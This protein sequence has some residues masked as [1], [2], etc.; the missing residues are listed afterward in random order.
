MPKED[1]VKDGGGRKRD[2]EEPP[3]FS[4]MK[5][6]KLVERARELADRYRVK[7]GER[8]RLSDVDPDDT[9]WL[10]EEDKPSPRRRS[11]GASRRSPS[12]RTCSTPRTAGACC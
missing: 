1:A 2:A 5:L 10:K 3:A 11:S 9:A 4:A 7:D 8:F 6:D 12:C